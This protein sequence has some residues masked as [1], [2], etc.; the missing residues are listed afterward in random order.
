MWFK[1][2]YQQ[3][4]KLKIWA[5]ILACFLVFNV[6]VFYQIKNEGLGNGL[7]PQCINSAT[8]RY[9]AFWNTEYSNELAQ[10]AI[11]EAEIAYEIDKESCYRQYLPDPIK[12]QVFK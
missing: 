2:S 10:D 6:I 11:N 12:E 4:D 5:I 8:E 3:I 9:V 7:L 1:L